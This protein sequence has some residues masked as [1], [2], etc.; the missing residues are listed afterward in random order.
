MC[1]RGARAVEAVGCARHDPHSRIA[2]REP[3][4]VDVG[5]DLHWRAPLV[6]IADD[7]PDACAAGGGVEELLSRPGIGG[8]YPDEL[9]GAGCCCEVHRRRV[10]HRRAAPAV[11]LGTDSGWVDVGAGR[12]DLGGGE[13]VPGAG[14]EGEL[15]LIGDGAHHAASA[16][17]VDGA[18]CDAGLG[19][20][21]RDC[22]VVLL[23]S[24]A[25]RGDDHDRE[26]SG[27][28]GQEELAPQVLARHR[29]GVR[30]RLMEVLGIRRR[31]RQRLAPQT[32]GQTEVVVVDGVVIGH[33]VSSL[34][35]RGACRRG[36]CPAARRAA[37]LPLAILR[38]Q[39]RYSI[40]TRST[41]AICSS[42]LRS[43][44]SSSGR[45]DSTNF[46]S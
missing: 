11:A 16:E 2:A 9:G 4:S 5:L 36:H 30:D 22:G 33:R 43:I 32:V 15:D 3:D 14:R 27:P 20:R 1:S 17:G 41:P 7:R 39:R 37:S 8:I 42:A 19:D 40:A 38:S 25:A 45:W 44:G 13:N 29:I 34:C 31:D 24:E 26:R 18:R 35:A 10:Q 12:E 23:E 46:R 6:A 28:L 21:R